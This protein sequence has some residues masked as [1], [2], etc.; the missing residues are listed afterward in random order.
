[1]NVFSDIHVITA[2]DEDSI[3]VEQGAGTVSIKSG[4]HRIVLTLTPA[5]FAEVADACKAAAEHVELEK[6]A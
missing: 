3:A 5:Q 2:F 6:A 1:M 4:Q